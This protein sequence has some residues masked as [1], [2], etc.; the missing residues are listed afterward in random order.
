MRHDEKAICNQ[1]IRPK[2]GTAA[3]YSYG[4]GQPP[5]PASCRRHPEMGGQAACKG[6]R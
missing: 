5:A 4:P 2:P 6:G 1:V 3:K